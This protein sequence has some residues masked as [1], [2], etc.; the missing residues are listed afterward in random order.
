M[1]S[2]K[3]QEPM[4]G[5]TTV[6]VQANIVVLLAAIF[7]IGLGEEL[8]VGFVPKVLEAF[9]AGAIV[10][11]AYQSIKDLLDAIYPY[12]GGLAADRL[13]TRQAL[14]L[15]N[16]LAVAGYVIYLFA[17]HWAWILIGTLFVAAWGSMSLPAT[18][19]V[20]AEGL[21]EGRRAIG[22]SVQSIIKR[23]P[24]VI[25]PVI[26][27]LLLA[28]RGVVPGFRLALVFTIAL[29]MLSLVVQQ[30]LY[31]RRAV[32]IGAPAAGM[33]GGFSMLGPGLRSLL[34]SDILARAA[35][36]IVEALVVIYATT[37]LGASI[38]LYGALRSLQMLVSILA[39]LPGG[40][41]ADRWSPRPMIALTFAFFGL[42]PLAFALR[43][44]LPA[45]PVAA[46]LTAAAVLA[47]LREIG[48][49]A[50]KAL[51]VDLADPSRRGQAVGAYYLV[52]GLVV[53]PA[54]LVGGLLWGI[55][56][57][58]PFVVAAAAGAAACLWFL[59][60]GPKAGRAS[61]MEA[62]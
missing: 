52:R 29:A 47:G 19:A 24:I 25:A 61:A 58:A 3:M 36:G 48:E 28:G 13:G 31:A 18:F 50:R 17:R 49:P 23:V 45:L 55:S 26:G 32:S 62:G 6:R 59:W 38:A 40:K 11:T 9:G 56:P 16:L 60:R 46:F 33:R 44:L 27:G 15:F 22:F 42:F 12:P 4:S 57:Q 1:A 34:A 54:P 14:V 8:W 20:I 51:I 39:Y 21:R 10:W 53:A 43:P 30:R 37:H 5:S 41:M 7:L 35:E 2:G